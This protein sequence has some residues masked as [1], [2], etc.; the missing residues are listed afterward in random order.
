MRIFLAYSSADLRI[1]SPLSSALR[2]LGYEVVR[3]ETFLEPGDDIER[4]VKEELLKSDALVL[5]WSSHSGRSG[6]ML[7]ELGFFLGSSSGKPVIP[8]V[9]D[10]APLPLDLSSRVYISA[11]DE[12]P[13]GIALKLASALSRAEGEIKKDR[14]VAAERKQ[15]LERTADSYIAQSLQALS[16]REVRY[17]RV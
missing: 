2:T 10:G 13:D 9:L 12:D 3:P 8:V 16:R 1:A 11:R 4:R 6:N 15:F 7:M 14:Q 5:L 17:Q